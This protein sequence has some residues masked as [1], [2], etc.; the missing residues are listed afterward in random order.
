MKCL[1]SLSYPT[2]TAK[3]Q[4]TI[5]YMNQKGLLFYRMCF[6][7]S[8]LSGHPYSKGLVQYFLD[9]SP[10]LF[11]VV[12][13]HHMYPP[14][15]ANADDFLAHLEQVKTDMLQICADFP[16]NPR[17]FVEICNEFNRDIDNSGNPDPIRAHWCRDL[18]K[19]I[20]DS[21]YTNP[22][23]QNKMWHPWSQLVNVN[24]ADPLAA[25]YTGHHY[26]FD[27]HTLEECK[28]EH[29]E[30]VNL[31][32]KMLITEGG[33][34]THH[35]FTFA[36]VTVLNDWLQWCDEHDVSFA[37]WY[38]TDVDSQIRNSYEENALVIPGNT[39]P[40]PPPGI[41]SLTVLPCLHGTY[42]MG[43]GTTTRTVNENIYVE[44]Y[45]ATGYKLD[46]Y[47]INGVFVA[48][49][50]AHLIVMDGDKIVEGIVSLITQP[51]GSHYAFSRFHSPVGLLPAA[52][53]QVLFVLRDKFIREEVHRKI[54]PLV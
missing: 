18:V 16:N 50:D 20:R 39:T 31:G 1:E 45:P 3:V 51:P 22:I 11:V 33:A 38:Y 8:W 10:G 35:S 23:V 49:T 42:N 34:T 40:P 19:L 41:T 29:Q 30:G 13:R 53:Q 28:A 48:D 54:H 2:T 47:N 5:E 44:C 37:I 15:N 43:V 27:I 12:D 24:N 52:A 9:N 6:S 17:V 4:E 14:N 21:G 26:Y 32:L 46:G 25:F 7:P 36:E